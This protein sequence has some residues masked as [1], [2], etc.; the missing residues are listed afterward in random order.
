MGGYR[1]ISEKTNGSPDV[2]K[3][4]EKRIR[5]A[6]NLSRNL[7]GILSPKG[8]LIEV[9]KTAL[10]FIG[11]DIDEVLGRPFWETAWWSNSPNAKN[12]LIEAIHE[13]QKG[14]V[15]RKSVIHFDTE[16]TPHYIDFTITP[17]FDEHGHVAYLMPE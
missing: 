11:A 1:A 3:T 6:F 15:V 7:I 5:S 10:D 8:M 13:A 12:I 4:S 16:E 17:V 2:S 9:N 14:K